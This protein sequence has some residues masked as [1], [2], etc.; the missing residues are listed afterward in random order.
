M[1]LNLSKL[2]FLI[3]QAEA[4]LMNPLEQEPVA[5]QPQ[6]EQVLVYRILRIIRPWAGHL[7]A[8]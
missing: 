8:R 2:Y 5:C 4:V 6:N 3:V 1:N 7:S